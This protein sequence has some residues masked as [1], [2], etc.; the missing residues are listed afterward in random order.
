MQPAPLNVLQRPEDGLVLTTLGRDCWKGV[1]LRRLEFSSDFSIQRPAH[2]GCNIAYLSTSK[3][4]IVQKRGGKIHEGRTFAGMVTIAPKGYDAAYEGDGLSVTSLRVPH[5]LMS[6]A[7]DEIYK[8]TRANYEI[9]NVFETCDATI[10]HFTN[11]LLN[12]LD[13]SAHPVQALITDAISSALA[14]HLLRSYN[15]FDTQEQLA[16]AL[17]QHVLSRVIAYIEDH[18]ENA[19]QLDEL[20]NI[21][22]VSRFHFSRIFKAS[23]GISPI[24]YVEQSRIRKAQQLIQLGQLPLAEIALIVG[25]ADQSHF[26]K[27]FKR[28]TGCTPYVFARNNGIQRLA[29]TSHY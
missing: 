4:R 22:G 9:I 13:R 19:I 3:N 7:S 16:T 14:A 23:T 21:A 8:R 10:G 25:F 1:T 6:R 11:L 5:E 26:T 24:A 27:R 18:A 17:G 28:Y 15:A 20:A 12:E 29:R 2:E